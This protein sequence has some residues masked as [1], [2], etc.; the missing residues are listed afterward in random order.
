MNNKVE[1]LLLYNWVDWFLN[2]V[3]IMDYEL[4]ISLKYE[5]TE[6]MIICKEFIG[7]KFIGYWD[8][9]IIESISAKSYGDVIDESLQAVQTNYQNPEIPYCDKHLTDQWNQ[10]D[11]KLIDKAILKVGCKDIELIEIS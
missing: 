9:S 6:V 3:A 7:I 8:E 1:S 11:I 2:K 4:S 5:M 10:L